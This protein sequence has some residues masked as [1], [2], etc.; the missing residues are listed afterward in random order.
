MMYKKFYSL[1]DQYRHG[2][3]FTYEPHTTTKTLTDG[4]QVKETRLV[5]V[6]H[7]L[8]AEHLIRYY[9]DDV[10]GRYNY[11]VLIGTCDQIKKVL[12]KLSD[13]TL[14]PKQKNTQIIKAM[15]LLRSVYDIY[16]KV[17]GTYTNNKGVECVTN[18]E[19]SKAALQYILEVSHRRKTD[20]KTG[21]K[22]NEID[23]GKAMKKNIEMAYFFQF[24]RLPHPKTGQN[25]A[26]NE[27]IEKRADSLKKKSKEQNYGQQTA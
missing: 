10:V 7:G 12:D 9:Q 8:T 15:A 2:Y 14:Q 1:E 22:T 17:I 21:M 4:T 18:V 20:R 26:I 25:Q 6:W 24:H 16:N 27:T 11:D 5:K 23:C 13:I 19:P 3:I